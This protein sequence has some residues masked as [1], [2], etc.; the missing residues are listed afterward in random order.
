MLVQVTQV[1][2]ALP[3][4]A[5]LWILTFA[6][7]LARGLSDDTYGGLDAT[8][9]LRWMQIRCRLQAIQVGDVYRMRQSG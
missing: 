8:V 5:R 6:R 1:A 9:G 3:A 2:R 4:G 7:G